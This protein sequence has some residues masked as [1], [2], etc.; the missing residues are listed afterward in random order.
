MLARLVMCYPHVAAAGDKLVLSG[1]AALSTD[2]EA[3]DGFLRV[4]DRA[5]AEVGQL[6]VPRHL[7]SDAAL[8]EAG[9]LF[10]V[11]RSSDF[12]SAGSFTPD[13]IFVGSVQGNVF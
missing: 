5:G 2:S 9:S 12:Y 1:T 10:V 4:F 3:V 11:S 8:T 7:I 6:V 13:S